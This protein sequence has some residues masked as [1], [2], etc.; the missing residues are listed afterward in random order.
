MSD[1]W[2]EV[3][4][5]VQLYVL[6]G[7]VVGSYNTVNTLTERVGRVE[8]LKEQGI[9]LTLDIW[10]LHIMTCIFNKS[11][12]LLALHFRW[13]R[14]VFFFIFFFYIYEHMWMILLQ[15]IN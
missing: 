7:V 9:S 3:S 1:D 8:I 11:Q 13:T 6:K 2:G 12:I 10:Y 15:P 14:R 4:G 5:S